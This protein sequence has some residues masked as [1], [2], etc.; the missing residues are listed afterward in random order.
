MSDV[1]NTK[2]GEIN[3]E[4]NGNAYGIAEKKKR[5]FNILQ[6]LPE[7]KG[8]IIMEYRNMIREIAEVKNETEEFDVLI[9]CMCNLT[10][11]ML[12]YKYTLDHYNGKESSTVLRDHVDRIGKSLGNLNAEI[13]VFADMIGGY[14]KVEKER[15]KKVEKMHKKVIDNNLNV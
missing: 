10:T 3:N 4:L 14:D 5:K 8:G 9:K 12:D 2:K 1:S 15:I 7:S 6:I 13:D 11:K